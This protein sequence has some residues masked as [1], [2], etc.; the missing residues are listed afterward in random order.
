MNMLKWVST[1][2]VATFFVVASNGVADQLDNEAKDAANV[3]PKAMLV[4]V[5]PE[6]KTVEVFRVSKLG[7][8]LKANKASTSEVE[9]A[10]SSIDTPANKVA[11]FKLSKNELDKDSSTEAWFYRWYGYSYRWNSWG[12][13]SPYYYNWNQPYYNPGYFT[14][15]YSYRYNY[16]WNYNY[17]NCYYGW[18]Y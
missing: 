15:G 1:A 18:Y 11:E 14:Y 10:I 3:A 6:A 8:A 4:K 17:N 2:L 5:N 13:Y 7:V 9:A 16:N 12:G